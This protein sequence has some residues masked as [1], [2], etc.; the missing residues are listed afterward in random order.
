MIQNGRTLAFHILLRIVKDGAYSNLVLSSALKDSALS[1]AER[2]FAAALVRTVIERQIT[3]DYQ[4]SLYLK[5][6][7]RKLRPEVCTALRIGA[8]QI[9]FMDKVPSSAA[10]NES[11][12][13]LKSG[14]G[15]A[16]AAGLC[17]AVLRKIASNG[18]SLPEED[19]V[20][21]RSVRYS[22]PEWL[23]QMW[24]QV[25][26]SQ[27]AD[28]IME[29]FLQSA[30]LSIRVNT[31]RT[32]MQTLLDRLASEGVKAYAC[33]TVENALLLEKGSV[34]ETL[35]SFREGL[36]HV[37]GIASQLC[38]AALDAKKGET[39]YDVCAAPGGKS[40]TIAQQMRDEGEIVSCDLYPHRLKLIEDG[41]ARLGIRCIRTA[42]RDA[43]VPDT[44]FKKADR[45]LCDVPCSGLGVIGKKPEIRYKSPKDIDILSSL[46][47]DI[48][49]VSSSLVRK[50]GRLV[51][52]TC[53][54]NPKENEEVVLRFLSEHPAFRPA[55]LLSI[56]IRSAEGMATLFPQDT[57]GD[58]FFIATMTNLE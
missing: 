52:S 14:R 13:I 16:Y 7:L 2:A 46:Q 25:Y 55:D 40:F 18:L 26:G 41:A 30:P 21:A 6:P 54:L 19:S 48:L 50:G 58:G 29:A 47:Y 5:E 17:N 39:V 9:L 27:N 36:F 43:S 10:V 57:Q 34:P 4:L 24:S 31:L 12:H 51:Y 11:V 1:G 3:I 22:C 44:G 28:A 38:C 49:C 56:G 8:A 53:S 35:S 37:Q 33:D 20:F 23:V 42:V 15:T 32:T 45:V